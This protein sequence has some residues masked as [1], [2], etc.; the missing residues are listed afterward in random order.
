[1]L[2]QGEVTERTDKHWK[3]FKNVVWEVNDDELGFER[4]LLNV[5]LG[6]VAVRE[7]ADL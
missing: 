5:L 1:M 3:D 7:N 4:V 2:L 6:H